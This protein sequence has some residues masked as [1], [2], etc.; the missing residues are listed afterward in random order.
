MDLGVLPLF[1]LIFNQTKWNILNPVTLYKSPVSHTSLSHFTFFPYLVYLYPVTHRAFFLIKKFA[2]MSAG[3]SPGDWIILLLSILGI[4]LSIGFLILFLQFFYRKYALYFPDNSWYLQLSIVLAT[5]LIFVSTLIYKWYPASTTTFGVF[6]LIVV[7]SCLLVNAVNLMLMFLEKQVLSSYALTLM[8][9]FCSLLCIIFI[10]GHREF[11]LWELVGQ[12]ATNQS[13]ALNTTNSSTG[14]ATETQ[15][16]DKVNLFECVF[17]LYAYYLIT[18]ALLISLYAA[19]KSLYGRL[20]TLTLSLLWMSLT[21]DWA[22][23]GPVTT[24]YVLLTDG[25]ILLSAY[26]FPQVLLLYARHRFLR[27]AL[28]EPTISLQTTL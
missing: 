13:S 2:T 7:A 23:A 1:A 14:N 18:A 5:A 27:V 9:L 19:T 26:I 12:N 11:N 3:W 20:L 4:F 28:R 15:H 22:L 25:Y 21:V 8:A 10:C 6:P 24:V 16:R 17:F